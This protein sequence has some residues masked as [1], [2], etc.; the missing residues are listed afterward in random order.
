MRQNLKIQLIKKFDR[1]YATHCIE[2]LGSS[3]QSH[4]FPSNVRAENT[5]NTYTTYHHYLLAPGF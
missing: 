5:G 2:C 4:V 3:P 1:V